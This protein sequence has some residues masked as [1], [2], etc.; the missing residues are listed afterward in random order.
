MR[1]GSSSLIRRFFS[2]TNLHASKRTPR[3]AIV[4]SGPAGFYSAQYLL[5]VIFT[6]DSVHVSIDKF[7]YAEFGGWFRGYVWEVSCSVWIGT[8][9]RRAWSSG[10]QGSY[11]KFPFWKTLV[12]VRYSTPTRSLSKLGFWIRK[13][14]W[15]DAQDS[16]EKKTPGA[17]GAPS[18]L[19]L[20]CAAHPWYEFVEQ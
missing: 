2:S 10:S 17:P 3:F 16:G 4:G 20:P 13:I 1:R 15:F 14:F 11:L 12:N 6:Y 8:L 19:R 5:K 7:I 18:M 9:W